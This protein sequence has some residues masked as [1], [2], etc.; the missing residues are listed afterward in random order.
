M[1]ILAKQF[2]IYKYVSRWVL[3]YGKYVLKSVLELTNFENVASRFWAIK[4]VFLTESD[5]LLVLLN[6]RLRRRKS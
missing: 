3:T 1:I 6:N 5:T 4:A 2:F